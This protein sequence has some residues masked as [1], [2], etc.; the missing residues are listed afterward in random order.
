M[1]QPSFR[2]NKKHREDIAQ[3][4]LQNWDKHNQLQSVFTDAHRIDVIRAILAS[5]ANT[6]TGRHHAAL[7]D[8]ANQRD[9]TWFTSHV[10]SSIMRDGVPYRILDKQGI[11]RTTR[12]IN[13]PVFVAKTFAPY[14]TELAHSSVRLRLN[15]DGTG[16][17]IDWGAVT[18]DSLI[19]EEEWL[20]AASEVYGSTVTY[21]VLQD[22][23]CGID[24][25]VIGFINAT[26]AVIEEHKL[27]Y[28]ALFKDYSRQLREWKALRKQVSEEVMDTLEQF[29]TSKQLLEGWPEIINYMP[30]HLLTTDAIKL[31]T[32]SVS[33]LNQRLGI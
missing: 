17:T 22:M 23:D 16:L 29:N 18:E 8:L 12:R 28:Y 13:I 24:V 6:P 25:P 30:P 32:I 3:A 2:L 27:P 14:W 4:V 11:E 9:V 26:T 21:K 19:T 7:L 31:P 15:R 20:A 33:R 5:Y 1:N 10:F